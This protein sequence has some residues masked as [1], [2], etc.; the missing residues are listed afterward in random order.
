MSQ[1]G[2]GSELF[3]Q[4]VDPAVT[5]TTWMNGRRADHVAASATEVEAGG[6][7]GSVAEAS[8]QH[9]QLESAASSNDRTS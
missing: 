7:A 2:A 9:V 1:P 3:E 5:M 4:W 8:G 6:N